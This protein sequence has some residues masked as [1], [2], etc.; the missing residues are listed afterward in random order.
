MSDDAKQK[1]LEGL[2]D[3]EPALRDWLSWIAGVQ[4]GMAHGIVE[5]ARRIPPDTLPTAVGKAI[6]PNYT[7]ERQLPLLT[8]EYCSLSVQTAF[9]YL[10]L[11]IRFGGATVWQ[12]RLSYQ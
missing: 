7:D 9:G 6:V 4:E 5:L 11:R 12:M 10:D 2:D 1:A 8:P 3:L